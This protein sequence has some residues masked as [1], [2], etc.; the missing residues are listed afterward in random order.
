MYRESC[1][2]IPQVARKKL[3]VKVMSV[4]KNYDDSLFSTDDAQKLY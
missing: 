1:K 3:Y 2:I 4:I